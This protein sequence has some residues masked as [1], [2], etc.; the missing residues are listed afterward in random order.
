MGIVAKRAK[1]H[2]F[3]NLEKGQN[4]TFD[5]EKCEKVPKKAIFGC[6]E[7]HV[8]RD[9]EKTFWFF[10]V[11]FVFFVNVSEDFK[12]TVLKNVKKN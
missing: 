2:V 10:C 1:K 12:K 3:K 5:G 6:F 11:T 4:H 7:K 9:F 8:F